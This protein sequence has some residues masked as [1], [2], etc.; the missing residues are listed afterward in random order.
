MKDSQ[1]LVCAL[2]ATVL[3]LAPHHARE[4]G[5]GEKQQP[6][7]QGDSSLSV[8]TAEATQAADV[9]QQPAARQQKSSDVS[10]SRRLGPDAAAAAGSSTQDLSQELHLPEVNTAKFRKLGEAEELAAPRYCVLLCDTLAHCT[11]AAVCVLHAQ[12]PRTSAGP[13]AQLSTAALGY[14]ERA[15]TTPQLWGTSAA[16]WRQKELSCTG[17]TART[18]LHHPSTGARCSQRHCQ[19]WRSRNSMAP[20][21]TLRCKLPQRYTHPAQHPLPVV[22]AAAESGLIR[23]VVL[24]WG[25]HGRPQHSCLPADSREC[26]GCLRSTWRAAHRMLP[27]C[28]ADCRRG[29][30]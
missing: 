17:P 10:M 5:P 3:L 24:C 4:I 22:C 25:L 23:C 1:L 2:L 13:S 18:H 28:C 11:R 15:G 20:Q 16:G 19:T 29:C 21:S 26:Q 6:S 8:A 7:S 30:I 12:Q 27:G 14:L 9:L